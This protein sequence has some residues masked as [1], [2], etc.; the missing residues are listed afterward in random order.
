MLIQRLSR[1]LF[2]KNIYTRHNR[3]KKD[4]D[5]STADIIIINE[6]RKKTYI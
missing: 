4:I 5:D 6:M 1:K 3:I 2:V